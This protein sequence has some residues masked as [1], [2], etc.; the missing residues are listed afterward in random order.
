[1]AATRKVAAMPRIFVAGAQLAALYGSEITQLPT[2][3]TKELERTAAM[4][5]PVRPMAVPA[6]VK[7]LWYP[8]A[9]HPLVKARSPHAHVRQERS[10][11]AHTTTPE[12]WVKLA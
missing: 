6:S 12:H 10:G 11:K 7:L 1:M 3:T 9:Q 2:E 5:S 4:A 8:Y